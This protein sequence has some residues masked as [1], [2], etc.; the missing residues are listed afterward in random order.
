MTVPS[1]G[2][3]GRTAHPCRAQP[4]PVTGVDGLWGRVVPGERVKVSP[5]EVATM[6]RI[7]I[8]KRPSRPQSRPPLDL[9]TPSG[10]PLPY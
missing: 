2:P 6:E 1:A 9:R 8:S 7:R 5:E 4:G 10:R 3:L